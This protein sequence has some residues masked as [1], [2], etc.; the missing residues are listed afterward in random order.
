MMIW[1]ECWQQYHLEEPFT[2]TWNA[3]RYIITIHLPL[4]SIVTLPLLLGWKFPELF[5]PVHVIF[6]ELLMGPTCSIVFENEP[7]DGNEM[8][9]AP[10]KSTASLF[11]WKELASS[12]FQGAIIGGVI[13]SLVFV[14]MQQGANEAVCRT[15]A[16]TA[17]VVCQYVAYPY[18]K[19]R[20]AAIF[21][22]SEK[23]E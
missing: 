14:A 20:F 19:I 18:G 10:R 21:R 9:E 7:A 11:T 3:I 23:K 15:I 1:Q 6:L 4:I 13:L 8:H 5:T 12:L 17:L 22:I 16:F 2:K